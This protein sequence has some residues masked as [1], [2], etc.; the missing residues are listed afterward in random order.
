MVATDQDAIAAADTAARAARARSLLYSLDYDLA[1]AAL[2]DAI[3]ADPRNPSA[4][5]QLAAADWLK[6]LFDGGA[7]LV[8]DYLGEVKQR[9]RRA[10][11]APD[12][13]TEFHQAIA[14][15]IAL[16]D[17]RVR[18][19]PHDADARF[20]LGAALGYLA[21]YTATIDR[22]VLQLDARR[23]D[24]GLIVG[25][26]RYAVSTLPAPWRLL[27]HFAGFGGGRERGLRMVEEAA[28]Y[29]ADS[30]V[31]ALFTLIVMYSREARD[32]AAL[33]VL[34]QLQHD[35]PRNRLLWLEAGSTAPRAGRPAAARQWLEAGLQKLSADSRPRAFGEDARWRLTYG[36]TLAAL[37]DRAGAQRE[38]AAALA[39]DAP[40]W[41]R[42]RAHKEAGSIADA[43]GGRTNAADHY[44]L[45]IR[46]CGADDDAACVDDAKRL[47]DASRRAGAGNAVRP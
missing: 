34:R 28:A 1:R 33:D 43:A 37:H 2:G 9:P 42:G 14:R 20:E 12:L 18:D 39:L 8:D 11:P 22:R 41:V 44:R 23:Q 5:R 27:A 47:L 26:Y 16:S 38:L 6:L 21:S 19:R 31:N 45:A 10:P 32:D 25:L 7:V 36:T 4:Y 40:D 29:P 35:Y 30:R 15:A 13:D 24:A 46:L 3:A 17:E